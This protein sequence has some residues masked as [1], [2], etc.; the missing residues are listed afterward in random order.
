MDGG[1]GGICGGGAGDGAAPDVA[2]PV[3]MAVVRK[4][5]SPQTTG[6]ELPSPGMSVFQRTFSVA[7]QVS[8]ASPT[9]M[10]SAAGPRQ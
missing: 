7:L 4:M 9:A 8:G 3:L 10:P 5:K 6:L 2:A 1:V